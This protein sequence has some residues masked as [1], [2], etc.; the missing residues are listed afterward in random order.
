MVQPLINISRRQALFYAV[1]LVLYEFLTYVAND[2]IMPG[3]LDVVK[4]FGAPETTIATALTAYVLGGASLQLFLGP[5]SDRFGRRPVMI[6]GVI[7]FLICTIVIAYSSN[8]NQFLHARFFQG[9]GLCFIGVIG[10]ATLQEIFA[11]NDAIKL[12]AIMANVSIMAPLLGPLLGSLFI[13]YFDWRMIFIIIAALTLIALWGLWRYMPEPVGQVKS[14]GE[15]IKVESLSLLNILKNYL[16]LIINH[17]FL[18]GSIAN[19]ILMTPCLAWIALAPIIL[20]SKA[21]LTIFQYAVW[22]IPVFGAS[23]LGNFLLHY[24]SGRRSARFNLFLGAVI[25]IV[26]LLLTMVLPFINNFD[27]IWMMPG[28]IC[29]FFGLGIAT[30]PAQRL[31][32]F[33]TSV[34]KG[35]ASS[36]MSLIYMGIMARGI[37]YANDYYA[38]QGNMSFTLFCAA[39]GLIYM[40]LAAVAF[41]IKKADKAA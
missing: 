20:M 3:M 9:M 13:H 40:L 1:F 25:S 11:E 24:L 15:M 12:I 2:M 7:L 36:L 23:I 29:Y 10:Y 4:S 18:L 26:S 27:F 19:A 8:I 21:H 37:E 39:C 32:L 14:D 33:S 41:G 30:G 6:F 35:T 31:I 38:L 34:A 16:K 28:V 17:T 22:Q 5:I